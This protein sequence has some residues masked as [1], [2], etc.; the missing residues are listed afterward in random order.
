MPETAPSPV[1]RS[2]I[3]REERDEL[4]MAL[5]QAFSEAI[6]AADSYG[7][8]NCQD[9]HE[10]KMK[11]WQAMTAVIIGDHRSRRDSQFC[12]QQDALFRLSSAM[13]YRSLTA[14]GWPIAFGMSDDLFFMK[15]WTFS[16]C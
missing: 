12:E 15:Y 10:R 13:L 2:R 9:P 11:V 3:D 16:G 14:Q 6:D 8:G 1:C 5:A 4:R 7:L